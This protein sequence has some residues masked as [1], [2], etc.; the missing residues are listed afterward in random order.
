MEYQFNIVNLIKPDS[1]YNHGMKPL[2]YSEKH[3]Q[4]TGNGWYRGGYDIKYFQSPNKVK[5]ITGNEITHFILSFKITF[6]YDDDIVYL[7]HCYPYTY[8]D[9]VSYLN[10]VCNPVNT[11][12][13]LKRT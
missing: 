4:V 11:K 6:E 5:K 2:V 12:G 8:S 9:L 10:R 3:V 7:S 1:S 13:K